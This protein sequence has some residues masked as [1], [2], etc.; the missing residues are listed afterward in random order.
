M[1][2]NVFNKTAKG[3]RKEAVNALARA[4]EQSNAIKSPSQVI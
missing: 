4:W 2:L 3:L 1:N